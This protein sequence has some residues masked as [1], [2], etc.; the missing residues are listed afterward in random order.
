MKAVPPKSH[1]TKS[2]TPKHA[3]VNFASGFT[4]IELLVVISI[5]SLLVAIL[6]PALSAAREAGRTVSCL[7]TVRQMSYA[8]TIYASDNKD[9]IPMASQDNAPNDL[10]PWWK[11]LRDDYLEGDK[12]GAM[13]CPNAEDGGR[14]YNHSIPGAPFFE[15]VS[16]AG[17]NHYNHG[18]DY[19]INSFYSSRNDQWWYSHPVNPTYR[20]LLEMQNPSALFCFTES[21]NVWL[22]GWA[23]GNHLMFRHGTKNDVINIGFFDGHAE[24]WGELEAGTGESRLINI[25]G[26]PWYADQLPWQDRA[27]REIE[28]YDPTP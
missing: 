4:L 10:D 7:S 14:R 6:L 2:S 21:Q 28:R 27:W 11:L 12:E 16:T 19:A 1:N 13:M 26:P 5:I 9:Y 18:F 20:S 24:S 25:L 17:G 15:P 3:Q 22:G 23:P 8:L